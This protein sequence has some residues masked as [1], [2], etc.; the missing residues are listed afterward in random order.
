M[1]QPVAVVEKRSPLPNVIRYEANRTLTGMGHER[2]TRREQALDDSPGAELARRLFDTGHV[3]SVHLYANV[4]TVQLID[5]HRTT[6]LREVV[7]GLFRFYPGTPGAEPTA[8][9]D[10]LAVTPDDGASGVTT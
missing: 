8:P 3:A 7:E 10:D 5:G 1:G 4:I 6:G 9:V 2:Y